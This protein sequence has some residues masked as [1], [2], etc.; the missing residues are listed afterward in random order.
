MTDK[1]Q[2]RPKHK[3]TLECSYA[4]SFGLS[5]DASF[6]HVADQYYIAGAQSAKLNDYNLVDVKLMQRIIKDRL[7]A[8]IG[9]TNL[10]DEDYEQSY[11]FPQAGRIAYVGMK[12][13]F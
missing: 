11:G 5:A 1:L 6:M 7:Y 3:V 4:W 2:Y 13:M 10:L 9:A 12:L 8:Y